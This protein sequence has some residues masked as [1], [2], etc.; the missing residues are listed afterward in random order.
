MPGGTVQ[1]AGVSRRNG[2]DMGPRKYSVVIFET[3]ANADLYD[4][5]GPAFETDEIDEASGNVPDL[6]LVIV[7][8]WWDNVG[9]GDSANLETAIS[10]IR[11]A[12]S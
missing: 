7:K 11:K 10:A 3:D 12:L 8:Q 1:L 4:L 2:N 5:L 9:H 6:Q